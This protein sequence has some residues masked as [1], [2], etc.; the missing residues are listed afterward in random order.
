MTAAI[1]ST[2]ADTASLDF[3]LST[4]LRFMHNHHLLQIFDQPQWLTIKGGS[5]NYVDRIVSRLPKKQLH[6]GQAVKSVRT[7]TD[8][9]VIITT[10]KGDE[11]A[12][13]HVIMA[14]HAD[15]TLSLLNAGGGGVTDDE[16]DILGAFEFEKNRA[17]LHSDA[18][19]MP[20]RRSIWSAWN[21]LTT[22]D[23]R[24][25]AV[26]EMSLT[27]CMNLLQSLDEAEYGPVLVTMNPPFEPDPTTVLKEFRYEHPLFTAKVSVFSLH[28][29]SS[30]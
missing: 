3:P 15:T 28:F 29:R 10:D 9:K 2:P 19:L 17:V 1:W 25:G 8:R 12:Y 11:H 30:S 26:H 23:K 4:L 20:A 22:A 18:R 24:T 6:L 7:A 16:R 13:D 27:Y 14:T 5:R 21:Y